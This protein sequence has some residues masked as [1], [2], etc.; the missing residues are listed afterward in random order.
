MKRNSLSYWIIVL[1]VLSVL[2]SCAPEKFSDAPAPAEQNQNVTANV[3]YGADGRLDLYQLTDDR[4]RVMADSTVALIKNSNLTT[5]NGMTTI[6]TQN[7]GSSMNL[8]SDE[9]F[10]EQDTAAFCSGTLVGP[11]IILTA[12]HCIENLSDCQSTSMVFGFAVKAQGLTTKSVNA[13]EVYRC[14]EVI[15]TLRENAGA[16]FAIIRLDRKVTGHQARAVRPAGDVDAGASL[17]VIGHPVGLPTKVTTGGTI[18]SL[19]NIGYFVA[20]LD[21]YGGNSG[22]GVFNLSTGLIEGVLVRGE[23]DFVNRGTCTVSKICAEGTC[24]GE[25]VTKISSVRPFLPAVPVDPTPVDPPT[26]RPEKFSSNLKVAIPDNVIAG[27]VSE[28]QVGSVPKGRKVFVNLNISHTYIGDLNITLT[29]P[30]GKLVTLHARAGGSAD[31][32]VKS[33]EVT[34]SLGSISTAGIYKLR[35][36]DLAVRDSGNLES[37]SLEFK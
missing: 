25:D 17:V 13:G 12:G 2:V 20:N 8:C 3:I 26:S 18:R 34:S 23:Q 14:V 36:Q 29:A 11:D 24:R 6:K 9:K 21:T 28:L 22:S 1:T 33:Y 27:I 4:L 16:D 15:K 30:D 5:S 10:R 35:I 37:W 7:Y 32:I 19:A 31:N